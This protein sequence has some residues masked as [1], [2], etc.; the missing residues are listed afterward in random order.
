MNRRDALLTLCLV[1]AGCG[2][3]GA[4]RR[5]GL[6]DVGL[7]NHKFPALA[8]R[9]TPGAFSAGLI[10]L[11]SN[12]SW[13]WNAD[14]GLPLAGLFVLP[15]AAAALAEV[16][17]KRLGMGERITI[18][19]MDLS[20]PYSAIDQAWPTPPEHH[21][22]QMPAI[23]LISLAVQAGDNTAADVIMKRIG[24]PG[25]VTAWL[26]QVGISDMRVDRYAR[27]LE[28]ELAGMVP[29]RP[30]WKDE[31][32]WL[33]AR[34]T[35]PAAD[36]EGAMN[37]YLADPRDTAT[38]RAVVELLHRLA[39]GSLISPASARLLLRLMSSS[40]TGA[41]RFAAGL[42]KGAALAQVTSQ[43]RTDL[44]FTP[45]AN[46]AAIATLEDGG[47]VVMVA[48]LAGSTAT[49]A[50]RDRLFADTARLFLQ[51]LR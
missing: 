29:F 19:E 3:G 39:A 6:L 18:G 32:A 30:A 38:V 36:R 25:A 23:D 8:A 35:V 40:R 11:A 51:A 14:R 12:R 24:G 5:H 48:M 37:A 31:A 50:D 43:T 49:L 42:A 9:A 41:N 10:D 33:A 1:L 15:M 44:G 20:P 4:P 22:S 7:L 17:A 21:G 28:E 13:F 2:R 34:D 45:A 47:R 46:D 26:R 16:D 27:E